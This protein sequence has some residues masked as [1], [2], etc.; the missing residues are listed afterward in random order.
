MG[1]TDLSCRMDDSF[2]E[3]L[4]PAQELVHHIPF[5]CRELIVPPQRRPRK[6]NSHRQNLCV[7]L[8]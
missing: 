8:A 5:Y 4:P 1:T 2:I 3:F 7:K 6:K